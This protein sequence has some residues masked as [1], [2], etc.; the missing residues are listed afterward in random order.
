M[1]EVRLKGFRKMG[2]WRPLRRGDIS[3][4]GQGPPVRFEV[5]NAGSIAERGSAADQGGAGM[6]FLC[7]MRGHRHGGG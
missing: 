4:A 7:R 1:G 6:M 2:H 5:V 3:S